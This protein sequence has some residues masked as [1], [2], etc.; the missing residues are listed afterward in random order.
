MVSFDT[1]ILVCAADLNAGERHTIA[2]KL[3]NGAAWTGAALTEQSLI[4]FLSVVT[5]KQKQPSAAVSGMVRN[6]LELFPLLLPSETTV[7]D[8]MSLLSSYR[9]SVWDAH[10]LA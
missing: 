10:M 7:D 1:N 8:A 3:L 2:I 5:R 6:W 9:L 4:E